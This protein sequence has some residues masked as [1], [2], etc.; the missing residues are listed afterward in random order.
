MQVVCTSILCVLVVSIEGIEIKQKNK[1]SFMAGN[2]RNRY[3]GGKSRWLIWFHLYKANVSA[4]PTYF[5]QK[6]ILFSICF[7]CMN[8]QLLISISLETRS[9]E[10]DQKVCPLSTNKSLYHAI[11]NSILEEEEEQGSLLQQIKIPL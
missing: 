1:T 8:T 7:I 6:E 11:S 10:S 2:A 4:V 9:F 3:A 5:F